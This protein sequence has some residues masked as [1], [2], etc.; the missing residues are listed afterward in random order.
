MRLA[1]VASHP[2]QYQAPL[3]R[4]LARRLD[5]TVLFAHRATPQDQSEAGFGIDFD[6]D[7]DLLSGYD[8]AFLRNIAKRRGAER[9]RGCDTPEIGER[10]A[11]GRFDALLLAGWPL[12][13]Y[14]QALVA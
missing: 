13:T 4:Q 12:K 10:L 5:L 2:V 1:V 3:F 8:H 9:F 7:L 11:T 6:W 14:L